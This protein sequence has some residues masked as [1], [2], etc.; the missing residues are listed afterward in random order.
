RLAQSELDLD[1]GNAGVD[2]A[3]GKGMDEEQR[4]DAP[5]GVGS[6]G[7]AHFGP[8]SISV[9]MRSAPKRTS[10]SISALRRAGASG[11]SGLSRSTAPS[12]PSATI[13][14]SLSG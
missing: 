10:L 6:A 3:R 1:V 5:A 9:W 7:N 14:P 8:G 13:S 11:V 4:S 2:R 12:C